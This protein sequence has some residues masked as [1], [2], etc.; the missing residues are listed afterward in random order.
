M[1]TEGAF[2]AT[3]YAPI[4]FPPCPV[5]VFRKDQKGRTSLVASGA[6]LDLNPDRIVLKRIVLSGHPFKVNRRQAVVRYMFFNKG[7]TFSGSSYN[8]CIIDFRGH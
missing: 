3:V 8:G 1:P 7:M 2:C 5:L 4:I 6:V